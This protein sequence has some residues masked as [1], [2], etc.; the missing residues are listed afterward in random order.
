MD[1]KKL[2]KSE[3]SCQKKNA[4]CATVIG[5]AGR[6][7]TY[8][9]PMLVD[10]GYETTA[11]TRTLSPPYED[12]PAWHKV[13]RVLPDREKN[14]EFICKLNEMK[15]DIIVDLVNFNIEETEIL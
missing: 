15:P 6:I 3:K 4:M 1:E 10:N 13:D 2:R 12:A 7:G 5:T 9:I 14:P 11:I 8:L